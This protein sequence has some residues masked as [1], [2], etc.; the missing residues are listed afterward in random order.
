M[1]LDNTD[2][3]GIDVRLGDDG[4]LVVDR[5]GGLVFVGG[6]ENVAHA[7]TLRLKTAPGDLAL[8]PDYGST[9]PELVGA[10]QDPG[11]VEA[12]ARGIGRAIVEEDR[13]FLGIGKV[14]ATRLGPG[15]TAVRMEVQLSDGTRLN[16]ADATDVRLD[17]IDVTAA[18]GIGGRAVSGDVLPEV[19][20]ALVDDTRD[21][22]GEGPD[23]EAALGNT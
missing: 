18:T 3:Y 17:E 8:H 15:A 19:D 12:Q 9:L 5:A 7:L 13:R 22:L 23:L 21:D 2:P 16:V 1:A 4:D 10:K 20:A 6:A 14:Q 11:I